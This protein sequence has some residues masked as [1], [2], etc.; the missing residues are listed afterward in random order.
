MTKA[1][2]FK[3]MNFLANTKQTTNNEEVMEAYWLSL[4][5]LTHL[6]CVFK[7]CVVRSF[8]RDFDKTI[9]RFPTVS[10]FFEIHRE[11][12]TRVANETKPL[13]DCGSEGTSIWLRIELAIA[14]HNEYIAYM[15]KEEPGSYIRKPLLLI[16]KDKMTTDQL[17]LTKSVE[18]TILRYFCSDVVHLYKIEFTSIL[19]FCEKK[20]DI[21]KEIGVDY[22]EVSKSNEKNEIQKIVIE[23]ILGSENIEKLENKKIQKKHWNISNSLNIDIKD[24]TE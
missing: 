3:M 12:V 11:I 2:F 21:L 9:Q 6:E 7:K 24:D 1:D 22:I 16:D 5:H 23:A 4:K 20:M 8:Y 18:S 13:L 19:D 17:E 14:E 10:E 15:N